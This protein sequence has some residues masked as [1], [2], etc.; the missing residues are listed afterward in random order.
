[1]KKNALIIISNGFEDVEAVA[2]ID[3]LNRAGVE[4]SVASLVAGNVRA[5]YGS[6]LVPNMVLEQTE[7]TF[8]AVIYPGGM[9]NASNLASHPLAVKVAQ[10]QYAKGKLVAAICASPA[11]VLGEAAGIL[12]GKRATGD[13]SYRER[14]EASGA[15]VSDQMVTVDGNIITAIGPGASILFGLQLVESIVGKDNADLLA[16][17]WRVHR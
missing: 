11:F 4:V 7:M 3:L 6:V 15:I 12:K 17:R 10:I 16:K 13:P 8:D 5:S 1:M 2:P 14:L 9:P